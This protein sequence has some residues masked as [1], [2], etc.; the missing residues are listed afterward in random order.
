MR[1]TAG[2]APVHHE[3]LITPALVTPSGPTARVAR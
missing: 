3:H 1:H 2:R